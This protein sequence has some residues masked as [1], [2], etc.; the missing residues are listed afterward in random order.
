MRRVNCRLAPSAEWSVGRGTLG[1][2]LQSAAHPLLLCTRPPPCRFSLWQPRHC[3]LVFLCFCSKQSEWI[4]ELKLNRRRNCRLSHASNRYYLS[5]G[6]HLNANSTQNACTNP[7]MLH[8][9]PRCQNPHGES[10]LSFRYFHFFHDGDLGI[11][12]T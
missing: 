6:D 12:W 8:H 2:Q 5:H 9:P 3:T 1:K 4:Q 7:D 10:A 11:L